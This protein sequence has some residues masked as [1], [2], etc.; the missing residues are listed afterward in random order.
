MANPG[1]FQIQTKYTPFDE[2]YAS[3][4]ELYPTVTSQVLASVENSLET[5]ATPGDEPAYLDALVMHSPFPDAE[6]TLEA[7]TALITLVPSKVRLLGISNVTLP[8]LRM[9]SVAPVPPAIVQN[10]IRRS[11][12]AFDIDV[13]RWCAGQ[14]PV[15][16]Y[17]GFW[18]LTGNRS[19]WPHAGFVGRVAEGA[20]V[21]RP[22]AWYALLMAA[23]V[24][25]L[26]GTTDAAHMRG[27][28]D[29]LKKVETWR[30]GKGKQEWDISFAE[31]TQMIGI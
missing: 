20:G 22:V 15:V 21:E 24:V 1:W 17:Q 14:T 6:D 23:Q 11:E 18:T 28:L 4:T 13:R 5:L 2:P 25:I 7:W 27:D 26:N 31:F 19:E 29:G 30:E 8:T 3:Q 10:R 12:R 16:R 9:L